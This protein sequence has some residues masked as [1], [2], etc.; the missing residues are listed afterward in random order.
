MTMTTPPTRREILAA[1]AGATS[2]LAAACAGPR[3]RAETPAAPAG[4]ARVAFDGLALFD[5]RRVLDAVRSVGG[6]ALVPAF[7]ARLF[8]YQWL[9]ALAGAYRNFEEIA[10]DA[11]RASAAA[12]LG[13]TPAVDAEQ[14]LSEALLAL[15]PW[16]DVP[17]ALAAIAA[18][19]RS[20]ALLANMTPAMLETAVSGA[21][22][23]HTITELWST[24][25]LRTFKPDPLAYELALAGVEH[26]RDEV[27]FVAS[28]AWDAAGAS[29]F[30]LPTWWVNRLGGPVEEL[31]VGEQIVGSGPDLEPLLAWL[32]V[33][34]SSSSHGHRRER[35]QR[36]AC[37]APLAPEREPR[38]R[39]DRP[40][41]ESSTRP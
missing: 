3:V 26:A 10:L 39:A 27:L 25:A 9:R 2:W 28:A 22:L 12:T 29:W 17:E 34:R 1:A 7:R 37:G 32:S 33:S 16:P 15:E 40:C 41:S 5:P 30:G 13:A 11:L 36:A 38:A 19:G 31:G 8:Q 18:S 4:I 21:G 14:A 24:D 23:E 35:S 6:D 20:V